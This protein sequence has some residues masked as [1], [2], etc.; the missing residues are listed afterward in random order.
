MSKKIVLFDFCETLVDKATGDGFIEYFLRLNGKYVP[1]LKFLLYKTKTYWILSKLLKL[2]G[3]KLSKLGL[4]KGCSYE[5]LDDAAR[6]YCEALIQHHQTD[7][8]DKLKEHFNRGDKIV[9]ISGGYDIYLK[10]F[11][12]EMINN[13]LCTHISFSDGF[14]DGEFSGMDCLGLNKILKLKEVVDKADFYNNE[15]IF[16]SD[17]HSDLPLLL[18]VDKG[19]VVSDKLSQKWAKTYNL[20]EL[21]LK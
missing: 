18:M 13:L 17:H 5:M 15:T 2:K 9:I 21:I 14:C 12:P 8:V 4:V 7:I 19:I 10:Y 1:L 3:S 6:K 16:Y 20:K 11:Y